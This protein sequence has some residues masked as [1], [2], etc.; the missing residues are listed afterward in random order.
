MKIKTFITNSTPILLA[1]ILASSAVAG[2]TKSERNEFNFNAP[3]TKS[4]IA[5]KNFD[6]SHEYWQQAKTLIDDSAEQYLFD[7]PETRADVAARNFVYDQQYWEHAKAL[8][9]DAPYEPNNASD[10]RMAEGIT[11]SKALCESC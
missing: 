6:Y 2:E 4:D 3:L 9:E 8:I 5:A 11:G 1:L 7:A 10:N